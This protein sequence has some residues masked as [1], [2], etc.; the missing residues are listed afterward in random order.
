MRSHRAVGRGTAAPSDTRLWGPWRPED[1]VRQLN[2]AF[3]TAAGIAVCW[4]QVSG[5]GHLVDQV[6]WLNVAVGIVAAYSAMSIQALARTRRRCGLRR[7]TL[8]AAWASD[9]A[10]VASS[11]PA[12]SDDASLV[13]AK[14]MV[15]AHRQSCLLVA[16]KSVEA[17]PPGAPPCG[18]CE[19]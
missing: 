2:V 16:G 14:G 6:P 13:R 15:R 10:A 19:P 17:A 4:F 12:A 8:L 1:A 18:V 9:E 7:Q 5:T 3:L 11:A